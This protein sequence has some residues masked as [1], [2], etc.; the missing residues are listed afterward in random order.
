MFDLKSIAAG[1][2]LTEWIRGKSIDY[3]DEISAELLRERLGGLPLSKRFCADL[4][5]GALKC[6][7]RNYRDEVKS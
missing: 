6:A 7:L 4:A 1:S 5:V 2:F 3:A